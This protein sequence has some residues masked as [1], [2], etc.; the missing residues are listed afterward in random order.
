MPAD[1]SLSSTLIGN[2]SAVAG[3]FAASFIGAWLAARF[4]LYR[5]H[6]EKVWEKKTAAYT[7]I[8][9]AIHD[10]DRW[11]DIH[12]AEASGGYDLPEAKEEKLREDYTTAKANLS[13]R[14]DSEIWLI[15]IQCRVRTERLMQ[16]LAR[17]DEHWN[18][19]LGNG[20]EA[21]TRARDDL[22]KLVRIDLGLERNALMRRVLPPR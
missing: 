20:R 8:F 14:L 5:F 17:R 3:S 19:M 21:I 4:A 16:E 22:T 18:D 10:I 13:R 12:I 11:F 1:V 9:E 15:P 6:H 2:V 7:I